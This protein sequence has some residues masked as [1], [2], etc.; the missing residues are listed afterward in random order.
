MVSWPP[1]PVRS[2]RPRPRHCGP[3]RGRGPG[4]FVT[5]RHDDLTVTFADFAMF[6]VLAGTGVVAGGEG[7]GAVLVGIGVFDGVGHGS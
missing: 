7:D 1:N 2:F 3:G 4:S 5:D 6:R